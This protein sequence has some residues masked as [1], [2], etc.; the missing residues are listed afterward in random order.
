ME[1]WK[2]QLAEIQKVMRDEF[3]AQIKNSKESEKN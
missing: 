1:T 2:E 3:L